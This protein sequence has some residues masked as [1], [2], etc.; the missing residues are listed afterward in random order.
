MVEGSDGVEESFCE[1]VEGIP[2][3]VEG[4]PD[5]VDPL[6]GKDCCTPVGG[7]VLVWVWDFVGVGVD[8]C[9]WV[10]V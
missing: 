5:V 1:L 8:V 3:V 10:R 9:V 7:G 4:V 6:G 2:D